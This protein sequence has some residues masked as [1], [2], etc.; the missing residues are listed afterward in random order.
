MYPPSG[1]TSPDNNIFTSD[2]TGNT[3]SGSSSQS[4][5]EAI[6]E[7]LANLPEVKNVLNITASTQIKENMAAL[8]TEKQKSVDKTIGPLSGTVTEF[9]DAL[10]KLATTAE[11][12]KQEKENAD[13]L[14]ANNISNTTQTGFTTGYVQATIIQDNSGNNVPL[15]TSTQSDVS[16]AAE[17]QIQE[18]TE[19]I[20]VA[21][22]SFVAP[23]PDPTFSN[24]PPASGIITATDG[25]NFSYVVIA[26]SNDTNVDVT[27]DIVY[28]QTLA[29]IWLTSDTSVDNQLTLSGQPSSS[30]IGTTFFQINATSNNTTITQVFDISV[31]SSTPAPAPAPAPVNI[32]PQFDSQPITS[33]TEG[34][35]YK[36]PT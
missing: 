34:Q 28:P 26:D 4:V 22:I 36:H 10:L 29:G 1:T 27:F 17:E 21:D 8:V 20:V 23:L 16:Q 12:N 18:E 13:N 6:I 35:L 25:Q 33:A 19:N 3:G 2:D 31:V 11:V 32:L 30:D 5:N 14:A 24:F 15:T 9:N 7:K